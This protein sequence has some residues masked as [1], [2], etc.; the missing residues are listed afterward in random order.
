MMKASRHWERQ[1]TAERTA[2]CETP[3]L[4]VTSFGR[5]IGTMHRLDLTDHERAVLITTLRRLVDFDPQPVSPQVQA[6]R[7]ILERLEPQ[8][9]QAVPD[10]A[11]TG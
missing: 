1:F 11:S 4:D 8:K 10:T 7:A 2:E 6:L 5:Y 9:P 3:R